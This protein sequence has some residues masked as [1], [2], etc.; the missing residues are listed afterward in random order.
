MCCPFS[1]TSDGRVGTGRPGSQLHG[2]VT[3]GF[4]NGRKLYCYLLESNSAVP[5]VEREKVP[6]VYILLLL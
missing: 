5:C 2:V 1:Q 4:L 3:N 6:N